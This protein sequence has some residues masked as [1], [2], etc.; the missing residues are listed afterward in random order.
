MKDK[1]CES[2]GKC[3]NAVQKFADVHLVYFIVAL[4]F[5]ANALLCLCG[6]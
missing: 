2:N 4:R 3:H 5:I 1:D 6:I